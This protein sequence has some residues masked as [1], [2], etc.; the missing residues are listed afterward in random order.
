[1]F[2]SREKGR[3]LTIHEETEFHVFCISGSEL[4]LYRGME[5]KI[6]TS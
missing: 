4:Y 1:M 3:P 6:R 2:L 5:I